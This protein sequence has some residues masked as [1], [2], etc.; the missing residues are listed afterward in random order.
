MINE[1]AMVR[2]KE[3]ALI[4]G[5]N[6]MFVGQEIKELKLINQALIIL[7]TQHGLINE[8]TLQDIMNT[9]ELT[10]DLEKREQ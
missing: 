2:A 10:N 7:L 3:M 9:I 1:L 5:D 6:Q 8:N 4:N